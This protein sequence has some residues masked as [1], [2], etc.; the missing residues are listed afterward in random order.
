MNQVNVTAFQDASA[1][2][3]HPDLA[4]CMYDAGAV[5][6]DQ[7]LLSLHGEAHRVRRLL[8]FRV[9]RKNFFAYYEHEVFPPTLH[10]T[11]QPYLDAGRANLIEFG[12]R[13]T[14]NLTADFAGIDRPERTS[15]ETEVLFGLVKKFSEGATL[16]HSKRDRS[17]VEREVRAALEVLEQRFLKPSIA[18]RLSLLERFAADEIEEGA[19]PRDVLTVLLRNEDKVELPPEVLLREIAFYLQAGS[20]S[21]ANSMVHAVHEIF[22]WCD[23][24]PE[25]AVR[26]R[27][28]LLFLQRCVHESLR[29]H[30]ASPVAWRR[31]TCPVTLNTGDTAGEKDRIVIDL[32]AANRDR[33]VFGEDADQFNPARSLPPGVF[34]YGMTFGTGIHA[35]LGRDLDGGVIAREGIDPATHQYGLVTL[36]VSALLRAGARP[37]PNDPPTPDPATMRQNWGRYPVEFVS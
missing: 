25:D 9:F 8:E 10:A 27:D 5:V 24:H 16:V 12:Y 15:E 23:L 7:V 20:H 29:L 33:S 11:L 35:C 4:Q 21:T 13:V 31:P 2:L 34:P 32:A 14:I 37:S 18:R 6:M 3:R 22:R 28:D 17:E 36:L 1:A 26:V 19:L 30:P